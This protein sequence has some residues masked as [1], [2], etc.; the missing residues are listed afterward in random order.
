MVESSSRVLEEEN[1]WWNGGGR[2]EDC[3]GE[4][5]AH[6]NERLSLG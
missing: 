4:G 5:A 1:R 2:E 3:S 6:S